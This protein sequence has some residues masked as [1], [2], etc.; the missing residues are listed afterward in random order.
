MLDLSAFPVSSLEM[1]VSCQLRKMTVEVFS[2]AG[3]GTQYPNL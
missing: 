2:M 3:S 1:D